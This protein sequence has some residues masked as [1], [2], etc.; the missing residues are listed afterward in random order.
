M[1]KILMVLLAM[2]L[3]ILLAV[4]SANA[5]FTKKG[6]PAVPYLMD[7]G[8]VMGFFWQK[9]YKALNEMVAKGRCIILDDNIEV[10]VWAPEWASGE[11]QF[12]FP[13][14]STMYWADE[15]AFNYPSDK[16]QEWKESP[17]PTSKREWFVLKSFLWIKLNKTTKRE[18][19]QKYGNPASQD[20]DAISYKA[21][22]HPDF[23]EW[24]TINFIVNTSGVVEEIRAR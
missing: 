23:K 16:A 17:T 2:V 24:K 12:H 10:S 19:I 9:D 4:H 3:T 1:K 13:G 21:N 22:Q 14:S 5:A 8:D 15:R 20:E 11:R 6:W 18:I 7:L